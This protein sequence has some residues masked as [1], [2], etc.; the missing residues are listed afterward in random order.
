MTHSFTG[1]TTQSV[2]WCLRRLTY[3]V[4]DRSCSES[5]ITPIII[6]ICFYYLFI[7]LFILFLSIILPANE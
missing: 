5:F 7:Y 2:Q 3:A 1:V 4:L 6:I